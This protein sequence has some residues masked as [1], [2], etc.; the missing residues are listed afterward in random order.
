MRPVP[1]RPRHLQGPEIGYGAGLR[2][3]EDVIFF[4]DEGGAWQVGVDWDTVLTAWFVCLA[5]TAQPDEYA[6]EVVRVVDE[7]EHHAREGHLKKAR[8]AATPAQRKAIRT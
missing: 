6:R 2:I 3:P 7:F 4:A 1:P 8:A 5:A